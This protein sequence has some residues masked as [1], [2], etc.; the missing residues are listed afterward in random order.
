MHYG[1]EIHESVSCLL[2]TML[3][4]FL[5]VIFAK[6]LYWV[7]KCLELKIDQPHISF[8]YKMR[9]EVKPKMEG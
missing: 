2:D 5:M 7:F 9:G 6:I 4:N 8:F 1:N 3:R